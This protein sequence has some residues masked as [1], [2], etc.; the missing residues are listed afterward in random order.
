MK[1]LALAACLITLSVAGNVSVAQT[2]PGNTGVTTG[3]NVAPG[4]PLTPEQ[5]QN[6]KPMPM[7]SIK[8]APRKPPTTGSVR[9]GGAGA[10]P[11]STGLPG[12][13]TGTNLPSTGVPGS[14]NVPDSSPN[15]RN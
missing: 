12:G 14:G 6:A 8:G 3:R 4:A 13:P 5:M 2:V 11:G 15:S 10:A 9:H 7:P 1:K